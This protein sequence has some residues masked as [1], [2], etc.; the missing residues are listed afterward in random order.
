[1]IKLEIFTYLIENLDLKMNNDS[2][3][4]L[5]TFFINISWMKPEMTFKSG[6]TIFREK[7]Y[8]P[9]YFNFVILSL[10]SRIKSKI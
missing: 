10:L 3:P 5:G 2:F 7:H 6:V 4:N 8:G 9:K 1:M